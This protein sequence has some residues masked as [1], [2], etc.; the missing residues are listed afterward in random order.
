M[1]LAVVHHDAFVATLPAGHRFPMNKYAH[2]AE[3][4]RE[5]GIVSADGFIEPAEAPAAWLRFA[6]APSYVDQVLTSAVP[7]KIERE[8][9][10]PV[11][12]DIAR[13]A[14]LSSGATVLA[15]RLAAERGIAC[16]TAGGSHHARHAGGAGFCV[17][18]DVAVAARVMAA[19]GIVQALVVDLDV[20]QG[21]GTAEILSGAPEIFTFS[22]HGERNYPVRKVPGDLDV[23]LADGTGDADYLETLGEVLPSPLIRAHGQF[24]FQIT[25]RSVR[26]RPLSRHVQA[27]LARTSLPEDVTV[28]FDMDAL[29][30]S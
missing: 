21:D 12:A 4:L 25:L 15:A 3:I 5:D 24:R 16:T 23:G 7:P 28:V 11:A 2:L 29:S 22:M 9:G 30:F 27:V 1:P 20:H 19:D 13:R 18:N 10:F 6:H 26:A 14:R 17:F 8:I